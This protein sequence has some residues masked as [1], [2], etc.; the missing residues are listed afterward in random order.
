MRC[1]GPGGLWGRTVFCACDWDLDGT[2]DLVAG[3]AWH[4][5]LLINGHFPGCANPVLPA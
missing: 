4:N 2:R 1:Y 3:T 5:T